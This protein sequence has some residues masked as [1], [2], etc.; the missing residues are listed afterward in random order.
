MSKRRYQATT[1]QRINLCK[2]TDGL[3]DRRVV[4]AVD[5]AKEDFFAASRERGWRSCPARRS[6]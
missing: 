3:S 4:L 6:R 2:L 5:V 1:V